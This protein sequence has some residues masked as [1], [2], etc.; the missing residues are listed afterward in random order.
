MGGKFQNDVNLL[1]T[2]GSNIFGTL[3]GSSTGPDANGVINFKGAM[4]IFGGTRYY[5]GAKGSATFKGMLYTQDATINGVAVK[6]NT[7]DIC[8]N[9]NLR[10][11]TSMGASDLSVP[12]LWFAA[13]RM[14]SA[15]VVLAEEKRSGNDPIFAHRSK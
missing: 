15:P 12:C 1:A 10:V 9:G 13:D 8:F 14:D 2:D 4:L 7:A 6:A 11:M 3:D 5:T